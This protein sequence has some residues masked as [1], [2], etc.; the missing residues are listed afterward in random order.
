MAVP[1][2]FLVRLNPFPLL[3]AL[4]IAI[5]L[6]AQQP[7]PEP[8]T[9]TAAQV[10]TTPFVI[11][12][13]TTTINGY[14]MTSNLY[15]N[16]FTPPTIRIKPGDSLD[17]RV[18]NQMVPPTALKAGQQPPAGAASIL[19]EPPSRWSLLGVETLART[20]QIRHSMAMKME[21]PSYY[22]N[23]HYHGFG[24]TPL[25]NSDNVF[26]TIVPNQPEFRYHVP[27]PADHPPGLFWYHPHP[28]EISE[29]QLL[30]GMSGAIIVDG[31]EDLRPELRNLRQRVMLLKDPIMVKDGKQTQ[32]FTINGTSGT[33]T[34]D[35]RPGER[36]FWRIGD[37]GADSYFPLT[38][39]GLPFL[40]YAI[41]GN[42]LQTPTAMTRLDLYPG[43][44]YEVV[45]TGPPAG[46][47]VTL[48]KERVVFYRSGTTEFDN[49]MVNLA[50][51]VSG[52]TADKAAPMMKAAGGA[53]RPDIEEIRRGTV[54]RRCTW[55]FSE[56]ADFSEYYVNNKVYDVNRIDTQVK[57]G[58]YE[59]WT[60]RNDSPEIHAFHL[61]Q[62]DFLVTAID[63]KPVHMNHTNDVVNI[64]LKDTVVH[65]ITVKIPWIN[66]IIVGKFV[67]HCHVLL[68]EDRGMM[69]NVV[70]A[71]Q[72]L[73]NS[74]CQ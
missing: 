70:V 1:R 44:R 19:A 16:S 51:L 66:P 34:I 25:N 54:A 37:V 29:P 20:E 49:P 23:V 32:L 47:R 42:L 9:L 30:G 15:N 17:L 60:I 14:S 5:P 26:I 72:S 33:A 63:G 46:T 35:I 41:D 65:S 28:H 12:P 2:R 43:S 10:R 36:Q 55:T 7:L 31:I 74:A 68:H 61:H 57:L 56:K 52:G 64:P 4:A 71:N 13:G 18:V 27:L 8:P 73:P 3:A 67:F 69:A 45:V 11:K 38:L 53:T 24:V 59:E 6:A 62:T 58:T 48:R 22:T 50:T 21:V 39:G 40:V